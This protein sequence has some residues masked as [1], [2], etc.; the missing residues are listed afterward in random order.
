MANSMRAIGSTSFCRVALFGAS[1]NPDLGDQAVLLE[2]LRR[3]KR[4]YG[5][6]C[7]VYVFLDDASRLGFYSLDITCVAVDSLHRITIDCDYDL[8]SMRR[9]HGELIEYEYGTGRRSEFEK[10]HHVF[11]TIDVLHIVGSNDLNSNHPEA[12]EEVYVLARLA[13]RYG[14]KTIA[15]GIGVYPLEDRHVRLFTSIIDL[16]DVADFRDGSIDRVE[17]C[18]E[19]L[20]TGQGQIT[21]DDAISFGLDVPNTWRAL[22]SKDM[23]GIVAGHYANICLQQ[24][25][26]LYDP[27]L[28]DHLLQVLGSL[29]ESGVIDRVNVL[30]ENDESFAL[31]ENA[32]Q[33]RGCRVEQYVPINLATYHPYLAWY[34]ITH[35]SFNIGSTYYQAAFSL[36][37][38]I[39]VYSI[40]LNQQGMYQLGTI[41]TAYN[42]SWVISIENYSDV[43]INTFVNST[44]DTS[45]ILHEAKKN[46]AIR[47]SRKHKI[48]SSAYAVAGMTDDVLNKRLCRE[49]KIKVSI[50]IPVYN[51]QKYLKQCLDSVLEQTL[52][53][54]EV[55]CIDDGSTDNSRNILFEYSLRDNRVKV[56]TQSNAGVSCARNVGLANSIGEYVFFLDPDDWIA[57]PNALSVLYCS[58]KNHGVQAS[59]GQFIECACGGTAKPKSKWRGIQSG[60]EI[61]NEGRVS[62]RDFQ[63]DY[64]WI[65]FLYNRDMLVSNGFWFEN[66]T[67]YEDPIWFVRVMDAIDTFW[68]INTPVYCYRTGH[69]PRELPYTKVVDLVKGLKDNLQFAHTHEYDRLWDLTYWRI[70]HDFAPLIAPSLI[71]AD[72]NEELGMAFIALEAEIQR[73]RAVKP[74]LESILAVYYGNQIEK[75]KTEKNEITRK[76]KQELL[77]AENRGIAKGKREIRNSK[78]WKVGNLFCSAPRRVKNH[79][80]RELKKR[81]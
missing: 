1:A 24:N 30:A 43:T 53:D 48:I 72:F 78:T 11:S 7:I 36:A 76:H 79:I 20:D 18:E 70:T 38:E 31:F 40:A 35:A 54:F 50:I 4:M 23:N 2:N 17:A 14:V 33:E 29:I 28:L 67:F 34:I 3:I 80:K 27:K 63:F 57:A 66:R 6:N 71:Q 52:K 75:L 73:H 61:W 55:I 19:R 49:N 15:T 8:H 45:L 26:H 51:M 68:A 44:N 13:Q 41:H 5:E 25:Y 10:I 12:F 74:A 81:R 64:G 32:L 16:C 47:I 42:S 58:A 37:A 56:I 46:V 62:Y 60:Y 65:R 69:K 59:C 21:I 39:P 22:L 9:A 77:K